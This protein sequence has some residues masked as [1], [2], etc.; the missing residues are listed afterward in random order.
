VQRDSTSRLQDLIQPVSNPPLLQTSQAFR[1]K[2]RRLVVRLAQ[3][4]RSYADCYSAA[5]QYEDLANLSDAE[6]ERRG[7]APG[8][9]HRQVADA[10]PKWPGAK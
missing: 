4:A 7:I 9:L 3:Y 5:V 1:R 6:L 10:L 2:A 8:D